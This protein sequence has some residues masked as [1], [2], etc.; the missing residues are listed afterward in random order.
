M[1]QSHHHANRL[2]NQWTFIDTIDKIEIY[3]NQQNQLAEKHIVRADPK[4]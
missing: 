4:I 3:K 2:N 1:G